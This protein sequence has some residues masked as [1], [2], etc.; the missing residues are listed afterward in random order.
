MKSQSIAVVIA[1]AGGLCMALVGLNICQGLF[2]G[3]LQVVGM[4]VI[5]FLLDRQPKRLFLLIWVFTAIWLSV[6]VWWLY[7]ST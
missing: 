3:L 4:G 6:S 2:N 7:R 1:A 5:V